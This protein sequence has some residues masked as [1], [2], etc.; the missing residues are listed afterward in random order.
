[1]NSILL[2]LGDIHVPDV[3]PH[4]PEELARDRTRAA[5]WLTL[6]FWSASY[7]LATLVVYLSGNAHWLAITGMRVLP[8]CLRTGRG[9]RK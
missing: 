5:F 8:M 9:R 7:G 4:D 3:V 6:V 2:N 1:M